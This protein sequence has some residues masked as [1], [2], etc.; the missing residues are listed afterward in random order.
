MDPDG[1][2]AWISIHHIVQ[3]LIFL[4][5]MGVAAKRRNTRFAVSISLERSQ[6]CRSIGFSAPA[7]G[8]SEELIFRAFAITMIG[9]TVKG[10]AFNRKLS[11]AN[12]LAAIILALGIGIIAGIPLA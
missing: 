10:A 8:P 12:N 5:I 9:L 11:Y 3:A 7:L 4:I 1:A 6:Y 2:F